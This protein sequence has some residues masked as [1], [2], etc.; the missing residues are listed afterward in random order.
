[1]VSLTLRAEAGAQSKVQLGLFAPQTPEPSRLDVTLAR[2][3]AMVGDE[4]VGSPVL[5]DTHR[6]GGF[7][8]EGFPRSQSEIGAASEQTG[9]PGRHDADGAAA[10][11]A[12]A[13]VRVVVSPTATGI[14]TT[15]GQR[16]EAGTLKPVS[17][18]RREHVRD[19]GGVWTVEDEWLLVGAGCMG[20][21]VR[22]GMC[23]LQRTR[24]NSVA[25][26]L[27]CDRARNAWQLE[28]F[29]D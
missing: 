4:R 22:S 19:C 3:S 12:A 28:A 9:A 14:S 5:E 2:L 13:D 8:M 6:A 7:H 29:Y 24:R 11:A 23:W 21:G 1:M 16:H 17:S 10:R 20:R 26:L 25:C 27:T 15:P 18:R